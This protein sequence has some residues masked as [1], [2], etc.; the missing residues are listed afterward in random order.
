VTSL[1][2]SLLTVAALAAL[3][4]PVGPSGAMEPDAATASARPA[5]AAEPAAERSSSGAAFWANAGIEHL[6]RPGSAAHR[7][8]ILLGAMRAQ[9]ATLAMFAETTTRQVRAFRRLGGGAFAAVPGRRRGETS[10]VVYDT[11]AYR[12]ERTVPLR[13][14]TYHGRRVPETVAILLD[15]STGARVAA[16]AVHH[17]SSRTHRGAQGRWQKLA[18]QREMTVLRGLQSS[19]DGRLSIF[20]GGDFNQRETCRLVRQRGLVSPI[21][22][23]SSCP[24]ARPRIDQLFSDPTVSFSGYRAILHG[25]ALRA[26]DHTGVY[27]TA[28]RLRQPA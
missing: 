20:L 4:V 27:A 25:R 17:P 8:R 11:R 18:W 21:G 9:H 16:L 1:G 28:F 3:L 14:V 7:A 10:A 12:L 15:R 22:T 13:S 2:R 24:T 6:R 19:Y 5:A 23:V 26:T